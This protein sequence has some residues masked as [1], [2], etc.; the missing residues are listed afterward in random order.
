MLEHT[1]QYVWS[2]AEQAFLCVC[3]ER[4]AAPGDPDGDG[5]LTTA[6][7]TLI[8]RYLNGWQ[9]A[10]DPAKADFSGDGKV[11]IYDAVLILRALAGQS[12]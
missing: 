4:I 12:V 5:L 9:T 1:H 8:M 7:A 3:G 10:L 2:D 11:S 6:D